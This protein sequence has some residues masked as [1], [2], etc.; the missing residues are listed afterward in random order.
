MH[1]IPR[2]FHTHLQSPHN[3][4]QVYHNQRPDAARFDFATP[5]HANAA[6]LNEGP[7]PP[8]NANTHTHTHALSLSTEAI[9]KT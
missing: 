6:H 5:A 4:T 2:S 7:F 1:I 9:S 8:T 3:P